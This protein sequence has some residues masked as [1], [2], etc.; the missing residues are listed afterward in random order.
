MSAVLALL[1]SAYTYGQVSLGVDPQNRVAMHRFY[2]FAEEYTG[3]YRSYVVGFRQGPRT[4]EYVESNAGYYFENSLYEEFYYDEYLPADTTWVIRAYMRYM[5]EGSTWYGDWVAF[6]TSALSPVMAAPT[7]RL[8][9]FN[10]AGV[11]G[12]ASCDFYPNTNQSHAWVTMQIREE[13]GQW[14][15]FGQGVYSGYSLQ[16]VTSAV[17]GLRPGTG[18]EVRLAMARDT[19]NDT[20]VAGPSIVFRT[21]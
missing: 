3:F 13:Q 20:L 1:L 8:T 21:F 9:G 15:D 17:P 5:A 10:G 12:V 19:A 2:G 18:Y 14:V 11:T 16:T 6:K 4:D 7:I